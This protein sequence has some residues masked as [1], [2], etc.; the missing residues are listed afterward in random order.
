MNTTDNIKYWL[1]FSLAVGNRRISA[2]KL[3]SDHT[4]EEIYNMSES[5]LRKAG[6]SDGEFLNA[7]LIKDLRAAEKEIAAA[8]KYNITLVCPDSENYPQDLKDIDD[9]PYV[10]YR[11]GTY[12]ATGDDKLRIGIIGSR[13][14]SSYGLTV[15]HDLAYELAKRGVVIVSGMATGIDSSAHDGAVEAGGKTIAVL[16]CGVNVVYPKENASRMVNIMQHGEVMSEFAFDTPPYKWNF[17]QRNRIISGLSHGIIVVEAEEVS[18]TSI[19]AKLAL[20]QGKEL[21]AVPGNITSPNSVG[22]NRLIKNGAYIVTSVNDIL[23]QFDFLTYTEDDSDKPDSQPEALS[24]SQDIVS[25]DEVMP[26]QIIMEA[27]R[28]EA[29]SLDEISAHTGLPLP[30]VSSV[31]TLLEISGLVEALPGQKYIKT[32]KIR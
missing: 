11:R 16:G 6:V 17:P 21:F 7:L 28:T 14:A 9:S 1:W 20:E 4:P 13:R 10:I 31:M 2:N 27:V 24:A 25:D 8:D 26:E 30:K 3:L 32:S 29:L 22:T 23:E 12:D 18:G 15:A 19:T 5:D